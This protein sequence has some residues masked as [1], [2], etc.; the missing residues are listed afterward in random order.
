MA[1]YIGLDIGGTKIAGGMF[2]QDGALLAE[3]TVPTPQ[4][5]SSFL[6]VCK[7]IVQKLEQDSG[8]TGT[9]GVGVPALVSDG[10]VLASANLPYLKEK[11]LRDDLA[12]ILKSETRLTN[13]AN[14]MALAE[15]VDGAGAGF[16]SVLGL[17]IGTGVGA[18]FIYEGRVIDGPNGLA[19]EIGHLPLPHRGD[20]DVSFGACGCGQKDCIEQFISG[21]ALARLYTTMTGKDADAKTISDRARA[22]DAEALRVLDRYFEVAAKAMVVV[23]HAFDP[24][25]IVV[26]GGLYALPGFYEEVPKRWGKYALTAQPRTK[27]VPALHGPKSGMRGAAWLW[28]T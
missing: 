12:K 28:R 19:G 10:F 6:D 23:L 17:I 4:D 27:L 18:G 9:I 21:R 25:V 2:A 7:N 20:E 5:Y 26:S 8:K 22:G 11:H 3:L 14:C 16:P 1:Y 15:A 24:H 13:D